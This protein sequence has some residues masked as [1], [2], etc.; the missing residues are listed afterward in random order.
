MPTFVVLPV[1]DRPTL[2][3]S[4]CIDSLLAQ[5]SRPRHSL[6][7]D[8]SI[9]LQ[10]II[11]LDEA[12]LHVQATTP[13]SV[14]LRPRWFWLPNCLKPFTLIIASQVLSM[15]HTRSPF[16]RSFLALLSVHACLPMHFRAVKDFDFRL[17]RVLDPTRTCSRSARQKGCVCTTPTPT[18]AE[19]LWYEYLY[20]QRY[21]RGIV[22]GIRVMDC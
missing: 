2:G 14:L 5:G 21:K 16:P 8:F 11:L 18:H 22:R 9:L 13:F 4:I 15:P 10:F 12:M 7:S 17:R 3:L 20:Q 19:V 6:I 1:H